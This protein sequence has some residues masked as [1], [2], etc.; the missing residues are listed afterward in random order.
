MEPHYLLD[1]WKLILNFKITLSFH[2]HHIGY[3]L[4]STYCGRTSTQLIV[5][6]YDITMPWLVK[7]LVALLFGQH[8]L[9]TL[10]QYVWPIYEGPL[11]YSYTLRRWSSQ[12]S[13]FHD[14]ANVGPLLLYMLSGKLLHVVSGKR[15]PSRW[16]W[17][18]DCCCPSRLNIFYQ[19]ADS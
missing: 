14:S 4:K 9:I 15:F 16:N 13:V 6:R 19:M 10:P 3:L 12:Q 11:L 1:V 18:I 5:Y 7:M 2:S 8:E 17:L